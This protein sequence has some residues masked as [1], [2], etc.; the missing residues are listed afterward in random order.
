MV[1]TNL[2]YTNTQQ[3]LPDMGIL[4]LLSRHAKFFG[5]G[6]YF[7]GKLLVVDPYFQ[8]FSSRF[9]ID[10]LSAKICIAKANMVNIEY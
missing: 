7:A 4:S 9:Y 1:T 8:Y 2:E 3:D 10:K 5:S 6:V